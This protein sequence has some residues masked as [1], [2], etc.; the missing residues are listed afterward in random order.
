MTR[1]IETRNLS[2]FFGC[3]FRQDCFDI[4][5]DEQAVIDAY[6]AEVVGPEIEATAK[7]I[8][9][10]LEAC[11]DTDLEEFVDRHCCYY[12]AGDGYSARTWLN[13]IRSRLRAGPTPHRDAQASSTVSW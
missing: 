13:R 1:A 7:E 9:A 6:V 10:L 4:Y 8:D 5:R 11:S 3:Y 2:Q 12:Y